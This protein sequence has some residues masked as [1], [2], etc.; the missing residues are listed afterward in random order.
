MCILLTDTHWVGPPYRADADDIQ[1]DISFCDA[2]VAAV[3]QSEHTLP[4]CCNIEYPPEAR[5]QI[6]SREIGVCH[7]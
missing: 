2:S 6:K 4:T 5:L 7:M 1:V 3:L